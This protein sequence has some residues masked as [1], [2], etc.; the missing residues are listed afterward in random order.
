MLKKQKA[1]K[2]AKVLPVVVFVKAFLEQV[3]ARVW[4]H[5]S[6]TKQQRAQ[7]ETLVKSGEECI[8]TAQCR[9]KNILSANTKQAPSITDNVLAAIKAC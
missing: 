1:A 3:A 5:K 8:V 6:P 9:M 2:A 4:K 7:I